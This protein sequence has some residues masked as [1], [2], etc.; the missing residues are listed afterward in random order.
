ML[1]SLTCL[2]FGFVHDGGKDLVFS[3]THSH[4]AYQ[5]HLVKTQSFLCILFVKNQ[6]VIGA[7]TYS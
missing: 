1:R 6:V 4:P 7:Y 2:E 5:H 3:S